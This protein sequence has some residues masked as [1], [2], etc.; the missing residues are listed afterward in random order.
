VK[1]TTL[2]ASTSWKLVEPPVEATQ[3]KASCCGIP[4]EFSHEDGYRPPVT[5]GSAP[6]SVMGDLPTGVNA[7]A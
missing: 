1:L 6:D 5:V 4:L 2:A 3:P 7:T